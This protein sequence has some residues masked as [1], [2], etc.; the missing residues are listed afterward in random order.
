MMTRSA[1]EK[2]PVY[3]FW[4]TCRRLVLVRG[5]KTAIKRCPWYWE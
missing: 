2:E 1:P 3:S 5:S 4:N